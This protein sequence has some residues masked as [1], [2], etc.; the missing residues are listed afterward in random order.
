[1]SP[2]GLLL[3]LIALLLIGAHVAWMTW[4]GLGDPPAGWTYNDLLTILLTVTIIVMTA[5]GLGIALLAVWGY[6]N[7]RDGAIE[8]AEK[9]VSDKADSYLKSQAFRDTLDSAI[10]ERIKKEVAGELRD[11]Q[12]GVENGDGTAEEIP[13]LPPAPGGV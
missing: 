10:N 2:T 5:L 3:Y 13:D 11:L 1:M 12:Q 7:L 4:H 8:K 9:A 6:K